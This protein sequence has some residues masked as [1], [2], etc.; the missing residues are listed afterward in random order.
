MTLSS[1][2]DTYV[3]ISQGFHD[4]G[5]TVISSNGDV[6][7]AGHAERY[8]KQKN[9]KFLN[10]A[11][12]DDAKRYIGNNVS[13]NYY[14]R[15][16][17]TNLRR[18]YAGQRWQSHAE[19][20]QLL[21]ENNLSSS[22]TNWSHHLS[23]AA[24]AFQT[25]PYEKAAIVIV[26]AIGEWD[27]ATIWRACYDHEGRAVYDKLWSRKYPHS[28]GLFYTAMTKRIGLRPMED[29]YVLMGMAAYGK[30]TLVDEIRNSFIA[31]AK[32]IKFKQNMHL[33]IGDW[34]PDADKE[35]IAHS[36]QKI[37]EEMLTNI[38]LLARELTG[39]D[40]VCFGGGVAL[41]CSFNY[42]LRE[43]WNGAWIIPNPGDCGSSL[44]AAALGYGRKINWKSP[45]L[46]HDI[47]GKLDVKAVVDELIEKG[48]VGVA[49]GKA[50]FGPR[51]LGNR[52]LLGDPTRPGIKDI[53]N[54]VKRRQRYRPFAP[55][56]LAEQAKQWF[57]VTRGFNHEYMQYA[58]TATKALQYPAICHVD[59]TAR[60][61]TV[62]KDDSNMRKIIEAFHERTGCPIVLNTSLNIRGQPMVDDEADAKAFTNLYGVRVIT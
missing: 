29:E 40:V 18:L 20:K 27:T 56:I 12:L 28:I 3:G 62:F 17:I 52:S 5:L 32:D 22:M 50:E 60:V 2:I 23:H 39:L 43:I 59:G 11:I 25:S 41:N 61:Q 46:G 37:T 47:S 48:M 45:F 42:K 36:T 35:D 1:T 30:D 13:M 38:H 9:D 26:D 21:R 34:L 49:N 8:S 55:A 14:E 51:A 19:L 31:D 44:G 54:D 6:L 15:P 7:Y 33:G 24:A 58:V 16:F 4:A 10:Q 57:D 53:V